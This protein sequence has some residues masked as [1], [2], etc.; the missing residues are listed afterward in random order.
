MENIILARACGVFS[1]A[2]SLLLYNAGHSQAMNPNQ[3][4]WL[5]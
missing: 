2:E 5:R 1:L 3:T 4:N